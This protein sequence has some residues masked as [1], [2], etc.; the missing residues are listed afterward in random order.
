MKIQFITGILILLL[1][2]C[3]LQEPTPTDSGVEGQV[4]IG[5]VCPVVQEGMDCA[6]RPYQATLRVNNLNGR[7]IVQVQTDEDGRFKIPLPPGEYVLHP[8]SPNVLPY[9][10]EQPFTVEAGKFTQ[11]IITYDSG[12]R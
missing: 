2:T 5:P 6:D 8:E 3:S 10:S 4:F 11:L 7:K 9:A 12:I 1:A